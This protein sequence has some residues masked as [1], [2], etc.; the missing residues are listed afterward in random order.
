MNA[1][2]SLWA[3]TGLLWFLANDPGVPAALERCRLL[4]ARSIVVSARGGVV[5]G[6]EQASDATAFAFEPGSRLRVKILR[7][8]LSQ[9]A[10]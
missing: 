5:S 3:R 6:I 7:P 4:G 10:E 8:R 1:I 2:T 9:A